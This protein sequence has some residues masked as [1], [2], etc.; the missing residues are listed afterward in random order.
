MN[1]WERE[2]EQI[3]KDYADG[4][5][6]NKEYREMMSELQ[7]SW[8]AAAEDAAQDAYEREMCNWR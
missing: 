1:Q 3:E 4:L 6:T 7:R 8:R 2:E 5:I